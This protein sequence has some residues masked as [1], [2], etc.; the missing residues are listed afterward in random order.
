MLRVKDYELCSSLDIYDHSHRL[1]A[2][3]ACAQHAYQALHMHCCGP[4]QSCLQPPEYRQ[5]ADYGLLQRTRSAVDTTALPALVQR[6]S[7][8]R[9]TFRRVLGR[10]HWRRNVVQI[11]EWFLQVHTVC[12]PCRTAVDEVCHSTVS[13]TLQCKSWPLTGT[14]T[15]DT[16]TGSMAVHQPW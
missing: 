14:G 6:S 10:W 9:G 11:A 1:G 13:D 7:M 5:A 16:C 4:A 15:S 2:V 8:V 12:V 3:H